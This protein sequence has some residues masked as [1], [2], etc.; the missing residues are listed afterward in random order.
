MLFAPIFSMLSLGYASAYCPDGVARGAPFAVLRPSHEGSTPNTIFVGEI[1][2]VPSEVF[3]PGLVANLVFWTAMAAVV[4]ALLPR[5][6]YEP[7]ATR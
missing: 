6:L 1:A 4:L 7:R 5:R 2:R 3:L